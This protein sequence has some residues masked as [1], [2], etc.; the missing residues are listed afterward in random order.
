[1]QGG[2]EGVMNHH[3][4]YK[5][6]TM[7]EL[8]YFVILVGDLDSRTNHFEGRED[9]VILSHQDQFMPRNKSK[10]KEEENRP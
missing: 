6:M 10:E 2:F 3:P 8:H 4:T 1:M 5:S 7:L 9:D